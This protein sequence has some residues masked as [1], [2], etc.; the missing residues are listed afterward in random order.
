MK[1]IY[2]T[3]ILLVSIYA[4]SQTHLMYKCKNNT[5]RDS[6]STDLKSKGYVGYECEV[7]GIFINLQS[8]DTFCFNNTLMGYREVTLTEL[9]SNLKV[10]G[11]Y[12]E[13][14]SEIKEDLCSNVDVKTDKFNDEVSYNSPDVDDISFIKYKKKGVMR[15][16][17]S[18][19]IYDSYLSGY[20]NFGLTILFKSGKK[21]IRSKEKITVNTSSGSNWSYSVFFT[22]TSNEINLFKKE[23]IEAVK[24]Y[25][26]DAEITQGD[27]IKE[28]ANCVLVTPKVQTKKK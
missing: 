15:Q 14:K 7:N 3:L 5:Q 16:Y 4:N 19:Y 21:I 25:I 10:V 11:T 26:F 18:I 2:L 1:K 28:Y 12:T 24:L 27:K 8:D 20:N 6:I 13:V 22:P 9:Y 23:E 17:V